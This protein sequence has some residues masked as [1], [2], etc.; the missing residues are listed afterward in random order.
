MALTR[1]AR[2]RRPDPGRGVGPAD[3]VV[4]DLDLELL[5]L[6]ADGHV[7]VRRGAVLPDVGERL[8]DDEVGRRL[9]RHRQPLV[10]V[11]VELD[12]HGRAVGQGL[13]RGGEPA[14][15]EHGGMDPGRE[16]AQVVD[17][18]LGMLERVVDEA[19]GALGV[20]VPALLGEL[21][22]DHDVD[23]LLLG[24]VVEVA[25]EPSPLLVARLQDAGARGRQL[26][27]RIGIGEG[28]GH[29]LGGAGDALLRVG[30]QLEGA[31]AGSDHRAPEAAGDDDRRADRGADAHRARAGERAV[32]VIAT[33]GRSGPPGSGDAPR[34]CGRSRACRRSTSRASRPRSR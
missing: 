4:A 27:A 26:L 16:G 18:G 28:V 31:P 11:G 32:S 5:A 13:E 8:G 1:S 6:A 19:A 21:E 30:G 23:E 12:G 3:A 20:F 15:G 17:R 7:R 24:A 14:V 33:S 22:V 25:A 29:Q 10:E 9:D 34:R 2:P